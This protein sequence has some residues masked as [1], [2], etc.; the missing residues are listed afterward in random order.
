ML[1][2]NIYSD[3]EVAVREMIQNAHD[4]SIIRTTKDPGFR[5]P[6]IDLTFD[7]AARTLTITDNGTGMTES[8]LH[9]NLATIGESFTRIR[10][11]ELRGQQREEAA[12]L[13]GQFGI[14]LLSAFAIARQVEFFTH[15]YQSGGNGLR[16]TCEGDIHYSIEPVPKD[17][18]GTSVVLHLLDSKLDL[19]DERRLRHAIK[20]YADFLSVPILLNGHQINTCTPPWEQPD[21]AK[22]DYEEYIQQRYDLF[23]LGVIPFDSRKMPVPDDD[24]AE[25]PNVAGILFIPLIPRELAR[26]FGEVDVYV[27]R[28]FIKANERDLLPRWA[29]FAK[30]VINSPD[31]TP[32]LSRG[33]LVSDDNFKRIRRFLGS[34]ILTYLRLLQET[35]KEKLTMIVGVYN[36]TIK[37][38]ALEDG[39][40]FD[41]VC[42]LVRVNTDMGLVTMTEWS[43]ATTTATRCAYPLR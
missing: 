13:I 41:A 42:D 40:F 5:Q 30:G 36:N 32:T 37:A 31:I 20:K 35:A 27:S 1:G 43:C 28:M 23:P 25:L 14:G 2:E 17:D 7:K 26:D 22:F 15:T 39:D 16:W 33:E 12:L 9:K 21:D 38:R 4:G 34:L 8:E 3:P 18:I 19:L 10:K 6:R 11:Q 24:D 29:R